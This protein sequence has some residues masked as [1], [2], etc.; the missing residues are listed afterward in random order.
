AAIALEQRGGAVGAERQGAPGDTAER[1]ERAGGD[2]GEPHRAQAFGWLH[3]CA[4]GCAT[5]L[6]IKRTAYARID[7]D[8]PAGVSS[9]ARIGDRAAAARRRTIHSFTGQPCGK[10]ALSLAPPRL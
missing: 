2:T 9:Y 6:R 10:P 3:S 7:S 1:D 5:G 4:P 8:A